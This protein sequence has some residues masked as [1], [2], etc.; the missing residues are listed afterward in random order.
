M[1][2]VTGLVSRL[3]IFS[4]SVTHW[5][6]KSEVGKERDIERNVS[7]G[8]LV[9]FAGRHGR[10]ADW[11]LGVALHVS[12]RKHA[13]ERCNSSRCDGMGTDGNGSLQIQSVLI[14]R[15]E[16]AWVLKLGGSPYVGH[17]KLT[18]NCGAM[19]KAQLLYG[20]HCPIERRTDAS[21]HCS[22]PARRP[23]LS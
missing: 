19:Y 7:R 16:D 4:R 14:R 15:V 12:W 13:N 8:P 17:I 9:L 11:T 22:W 2:W 5:L 18:H 10:N 20:V 3:V 23:R 21:G 6:R 1:V